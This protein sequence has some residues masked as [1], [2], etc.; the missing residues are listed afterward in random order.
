MYE[1]A[2]QAESELSPVWHLDRGRALFVGPL[3]YN[4]PHTHSVPVYVASLDGSFRIEIG[5]AGWT[6]CGAAVVPA[7]TPYAFDVA[8]APLAV[9]YLE[10]DEGDR[11]T[12]APLVK[13]ARDVGGALLGET[14]ESAV[15]RQIYEMRDSPLW[16]GEALDALLG[17]AARRQ[18]RGIDPRI[19]RAVGLMSDTVEDAMSAA[20]VAHAVGL[21]SS[22]FQHLFAD[23]IGVPFRKFRSWQR[24]R[25]AIAEITTGST[26]ASAS[27]AAGFTDQ[28]H[29]A[30]TFRQTFGAPASPSL[31]RVRTA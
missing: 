2:A 31:R 26:F 24:L 13:D 23:E 10:P 27:Y 21:S 1:R 20:D 11:H 22:R 5:G 16:T 25:R 3:G 19:S 28:A 18:S 8:G 4:A 6:T 29:F 30:R 7:G 17:F 15:L 12:L 9:L 14:A